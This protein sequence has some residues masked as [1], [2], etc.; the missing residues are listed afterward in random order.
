MH[1]Q[2]AALGRAMLSLYGLTVGDQLGEL[3]FV[4]QDKFEQ[5]VNELKIPAGAWQFTDDTE[6][7]LSV[8]S[9]LAEFGEIKQAELMASFAQHHVMSRGYGPSMRRVLTEIQSGQDWQQVIA[10]SFAGQGSFGNGSAMR[11]GPLSAFF[12]RWSP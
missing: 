12:T 11:I 9:N 5:Q 8:V 10:A 6:M 2:D 3:F 7:A 4:D 1:N